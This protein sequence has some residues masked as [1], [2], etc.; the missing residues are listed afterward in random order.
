MSRKE[1]VAAA[2]AAGIKKASNKKSY[3]LR[4]QLKQLTNQIK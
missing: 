2:T 3:R 1:L 4:A